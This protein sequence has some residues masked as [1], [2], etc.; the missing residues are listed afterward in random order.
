MENSKNPAM[1]GGSTKNR[2]SP[3][4]R[5][6]SIPREARFSRVARAWATGCFQFRA[7]AV[8][9]N[10][11]RGSSATRAAS[12]SVNSNWRILKSSSVGG[13]PWGNRF[14]RSERLL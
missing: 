8:A 1:G 7:A 4:S 5:S 12:S 6:S 13:A 10:G 11:L 14:S 3:S 9:V 2:S